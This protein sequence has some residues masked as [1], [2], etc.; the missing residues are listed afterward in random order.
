MQLTI[1][2][3]KRWLHTVLAESQA[4]SAELPWQRKRQ[5]A[6]SRTKRRDDRLKPKLVRI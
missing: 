4:V 3:K 2:L 6:K 1:R 5:E